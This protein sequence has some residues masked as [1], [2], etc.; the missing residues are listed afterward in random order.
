MIMHETDRQPQS[1]RISLRTRL[2]L[3]A[4]LL[5]VV[6]VLMGLIRWRDIQLEHRGKLEL[7]RY[8]G[9]YTMAS[10]RRGPWVKSSFF[11][12]LYVT[13][14]NRVDAVDLSPHNWSA[15]SGRGTLPPLTDNALGLLHKFKGLRELDLRDAPIGDAGLEYLKRLSHLEQLDISGTQISEAGYRKLQAEL[16]E[17]TIKY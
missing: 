10:V 15:I 2:G 1:I 17:C 14:F 13:I 7:S 4:T 6:A 9:V 5:F 12:H 8:G 11:D 3:A 16:P